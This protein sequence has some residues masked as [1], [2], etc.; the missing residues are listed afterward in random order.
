V[1]SPPTPRQVLEELAHVAACHAAVKAGDPLKTEEIEALLA[2]REAAHM[3]ATCPHGRPTALILRK[4]DLEKQ[5][6]RDYAAGAKAAATDE[7]LPY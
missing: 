1:D 3:A 4:R 5:F 6:G 7:I 2:H